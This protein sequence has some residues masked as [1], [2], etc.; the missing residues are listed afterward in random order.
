M[1]FVDS[2]RI[3]AHYVRHRLL[4][5][6]MV[7]L[8]TALGV[9]VISAVL[10][11]YGNYIRSS[12][13]LLDNPAW[14][15]ISVQPNR[16]EFSGFVSIQRIDPETGASGPQVEFSFD[17]IAAAKSEC[18]SVD[19]GYVSFWER[20]QVGGQARER[21]IRPPV[22][23]GQEAREIPESK[24]RVPELSRSDDTGAGEEGG[25]IPPNATVEEFGGR[26]VTTDFFRAYGL[27]IAYG[28]L[29]TQ[30]DVDSAL[31][32]IV[33]G[34]STA[35]SLYPETDMQE[36][37][38]NRLR[39]NGVGYRVIGVLE[40]FSDDEAISYQIDRA[41]FIP[42]TVSQAYFYGRRIHS[43]TFSVADP[44]HLDEA[45]SQLEAFFRSTYGDDVEVV[46]RR[47]DYLEQR[48]RTMPILA[49]IGLLSSVGLVVAAINILNLMLARVVR[50]RK[51]IGI[52][53]ALGG[54]RRSIFK[55]YLTE[56]LGLGLLGGVVGIGVAGILIRLL[57]MILQTRA[58][59]GSTA[60][61]PLELTPQ[62]IGVA[63][64]ITLLVNLVFA[65]YPAYKASTVDPA[66]ALRS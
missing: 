34:A 66:D 14:R 52:S 39:L 19:Y 55:Q 10:G 16:E 29:F 20:L 40:P 36:I 44:E 12:Q 42:A 31:R 48:R 22:R 21:A 33:L 38:G 25:S 41:A 65:I 37:I 27:E 50:R 62:T 2:I 15:E 32:V 23:E 17:E 3:A 5:S 1:R 35:R 49:T 13:S 30:A 7:I 61:P 54:S 24:Q 26:A 57:A 4:E 60:G 6:F 64:A 56:S 11:I 53:V 28:S 59:D 9:G 51:A 43:L 18:P 45:V 63:L 47:A 8:G 58:P 46:N